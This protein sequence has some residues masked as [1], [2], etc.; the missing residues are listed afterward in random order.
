VCQLLPSDL[1][2]KC[3]TQSS[4]NSQIAPREEEND[5][6]PDMTAAVVHLN[7]LLTLKS[8]KSSYIAVIARVQSLPQLQS[9]GDESA[10]VAVLRQMAK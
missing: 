6:K 10:S 8:G 1:R 7:P 4:D 3:N 2:L 9:F 5:P